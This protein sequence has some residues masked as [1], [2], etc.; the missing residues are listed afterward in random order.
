MFF[1]LDF[2]PPNHAETCLELKL[3][4]YINKRYQHLQNEPIFSCNNQITM[5]EQIQGGLKRKK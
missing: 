4:W 1:L 2:G 5:L 3:E